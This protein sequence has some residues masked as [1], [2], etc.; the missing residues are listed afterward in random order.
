M[1]RA[2]E[3]KSQI[4]NHLPTPKPDIKHT[5]GGQLLN[6]RSASKDEHMAS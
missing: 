3:K 5:A 4:L 6:Q 2:V 1:T